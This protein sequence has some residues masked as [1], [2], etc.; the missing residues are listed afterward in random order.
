MVFKRSIY[1]PF[2]LADPFGILFYSKVLDLSH[3]IYEAWVKKL[4]IQWKDWFDNPK[5]ALP[6][7]AVTTHYLKPIYPGKSYD[8]WVK[9]K[10]IQ[11]SSFVL[12]FQFR[13]NGTPHCEIETVHAFI[14]KKTKKKIPIPKEI[15]KKL[16][17]SG[18]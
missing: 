15:A 2:R 4:G 1:I 8:V 10:R 17:S 3:D 7:R 11:N 16:L 9:P 5:W 6:I 14:D 18:L 13:K 12:N